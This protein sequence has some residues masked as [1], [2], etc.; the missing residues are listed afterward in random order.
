MAV[1][2]IQ[3]AKALG[4]DTVAE[5]VETTQQADR[6]RSLGYEVVQGYFFARPQSVEQLEEQLTEATRPVRAA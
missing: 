5:G 6:L 2:V 3:L 1:A 4:L